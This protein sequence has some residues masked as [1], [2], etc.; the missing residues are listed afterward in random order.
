MEHKNNYLLANN[1]NGLQHI[2]LPVTNIQHSRQFY[3]QFGFKEVMA[4]EFAFGN[5]LAQVSMMERAGVILELYQ[6]PGAERAAK[7]GP[8]DHI[9]FSVDNIDQAFAEL[10]ATGMEILEENAPM[11]LEFWERG[12][13]FFTIRG[14]DGEKL[15]FNQIL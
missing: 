14:P 6:L 10:K 5:G 12:C 11:R 7:D 15:E 8:V 2:G 3:Q 4:K 9:A 1:F 13:K